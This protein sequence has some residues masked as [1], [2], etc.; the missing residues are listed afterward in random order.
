MKTRRK[1]LLTTGAGLLTGQRFSLAQSRIRRVGN[2]GLSTLATGRP[3]YDSFKQGMLDLGW[4]EGSNVEYPYVYA[5]GD[6]TRVDR[7]AVEIVN[8]KSEVILCGA[9][10]G[11]RALQRATKT[12]PIVMA[13]ASNP[14][15]NGFVTSLARPGGNITGIA[16]QLE[17]L[18]GN[19][20]GIL[21]EVSPGARRIAILI[22]E[23]NG[24]HELFWANA[25]SAC[26][27]LN[28]VPLRV[29]ANVPAQVETA[30]EEIVR[31]RPDAVVVIADPMLYTV[32]ARLQKLMQA[33]QL[34]VVYQLHA[35]VRLGGLLSYSS[36]LR[37]N[38]RHAAKFVDKILKGA[39]PAT[40]PVE[41]PTTFELIINMKTAKTL[42]ITI[43][44]TV[45]LRADEVIR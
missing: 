2:L 18:L 21:H 17:D 39:N 4:R 6:M 3:N 20:I 25:Q 1:L 22:N 33:T 31:H 35:H 26:A 29:V 13:Y 23:T 19:L 42:G 24:S 7:L 45:L 36:S 32:R 8:Q 43:P 30:V 28:L 41:Q 12:I 40:L 16:S 11:V 14:V 38:Y 5:D 37:A 10:P 9:P 44:Q 15:G 27:A 34:P